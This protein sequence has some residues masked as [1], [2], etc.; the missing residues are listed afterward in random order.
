MTL[1]ATALLHWSLGSLFRL[2]LITGVDMSVDQSQ[3]LSSCFKSSFSPGTTSYREP[4]LVIGTARYEPGKT[5]LDTELSHQFGQ[6][7]LRDPCSLPECQDI[8]PLP[9]FGPT[10]RD[11]GLL[12]YTGPP[13][14]H[15]KNKS[16]RRRKL[17]RLV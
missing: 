3:C 13:V 6:W 15:P 7:N 8:A 16:W 12:L 4:R 9:V 14:K 17:L 2:R 11:E 10:S 5:K 1:L